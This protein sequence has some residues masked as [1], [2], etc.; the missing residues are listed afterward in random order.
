MF[1]MNVTSIFWPL[2]RAIATGRPLHMWHH[3]GARSPL[4]LHKR[5]LY[6]VTHFDFDIPFD[7]YWNGDFLVFHILQVMLAALDHI[8][9]YQEPSEYQQLVMK[10][11]H[12]G[13]YI[14]DVT[15]MFQQMGMCSS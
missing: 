12:N 1:S 10:A 9:A 14:D 7:I 6:G 5:C 3:I 2:V 11:R 4:L 8:Y 15:A 13:T